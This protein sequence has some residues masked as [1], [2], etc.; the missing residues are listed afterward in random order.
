MLLY[1]L[2]VNDDS[3]AIVLEPDIPGLWQTRSPDKTQT[4][5]ATKMSKM[6][7]V[8]E[9]YHLKCTFSLTCTSEGYIG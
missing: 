7:Q 1:S 6:D 8:C 5:A 2:A 4:T 3:A 9:I